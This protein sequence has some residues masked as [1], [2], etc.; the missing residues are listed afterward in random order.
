ME[1]KFNEVQSETKVR[2]YFARAAMQESICSWWIQGERSMVSHSKVKDFVPTLMTITLSPPQSL[3]G[4]INHVRLQQKRECLLSIYLQ[5]EGIFC[6]KGYFYKQAGVNLEFK[7]I[8]KVYRV[9]R[10]KGFRYQI[11]RGYEINVQIEKDSFP[12]NDL[13][14]EGLSFFVEEGSPKEFVANQKIPKLSFYLRQRRV[15]VGGVVQHLS[16]MQRGP[17]EKGIKVGIHLDRISESDAEFLSM[18][19]TEQ[20]VLNF[21]PDEAL[22]AKVTKR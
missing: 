1:D 20:V 4:A 11:P 19:I 21:H 18:Y 2:E 10:R 16:E 14:P 7:L 22:D 8:D 9:Q 6:F 15:E 3:S 17:K 5:A 12:L 13:A